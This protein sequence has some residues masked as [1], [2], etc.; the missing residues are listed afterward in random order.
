MRVLAL[1]ADLMF[2]EKIRSV[3]THLQVTALVVRDEARLLEEL[4]HDLDATVLLDLNA[5]NDRGFLALQA[6]RTDPALRSVRVVAFV[7]HVQ[8]ELV[9]R[10]R[11][12]GCERVL[13]RSEF[14]RRLPEIIGGGFIVGSDAK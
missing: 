8:I 4:H 6:L 10:A 11:A 7:S 5:P 14:T 9:E 2:A 3:A 1:V 13:A 12:L